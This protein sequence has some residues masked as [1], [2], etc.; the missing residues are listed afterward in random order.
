VSAFPTNSPPGLFLTGTDTDV[1]KTYVG[2]L[3]ARA[4]AAQGLRVGVYKPAASGCLFRDGTLV[5]DDAVQLWK[6]AGR[7]GE[8][9]RVCPQRFEAPLAP[10]L[11]ARAEGKRVDEQLLRTGV[12]YWRERSDFVL[13]EGAGGLLSPI[14]DETLVADLAAELGYPLI[15]VAANR[16]GTINHVLQTLFT[17]KDY[18]GRLKVAG[19]ILNEVS[20]PSNADPSRD[21]NPSEI[22]QRSP[23]PLLAHIP[24]QS[25]TIPNEINWQSLAAPS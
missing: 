6:A 4:I 1:G 5:S 11:A 8:L 19:I 18:R 12:Q 9:D 7:P 15:I 16:L 20:P 21:S 22:T 2:A 23:T 13:V 10:H 25:T 17:A 14:G 24:W 3:I